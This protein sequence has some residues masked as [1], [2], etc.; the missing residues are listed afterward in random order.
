MSCLREG[1]KPALASERDRNQA[2]PQRGNE[3]KEGAP[4]RSRGTPTPGSSQ[5]APGRSRGTPTPGGSNGG[6]RPVPQ[7]G[8]ETKPV[9]QRGNETMG[10]PARWAAASARTLARRL[11]R[12]R[13]W[14]LGG[15]VADALQWRAKVVRDALEAQWE[16]EQQ[17]GA[18]F[19]TLHEVMQ[20]A[21]LLRSCTRGRISE[22]EE[23]RNLS[24]W[25]RHAP[26]PGAVGLRAWPDGIDAG[27]LEQ[28]RDMMYVDQRTE[29]ESGQQDGPVNEEA[30]LAGV[31]TPRWAGGTP[32]EAASCA[33]SEDLDAEGVLDSKLDANEEEEEAHQEEVVPEQPEADNVA[34]PARA[35]TECLAGRAEPP[36]WARKPRPSAE[37]WTPEPSLAERAGRRARTSVLQERG[38]RSDRRCHLSKKWGSEAGPPVVLAAAS[39]RP[40]SSKGRVHSAACRTTLSPRTPWPSKEMQMPLLRS[41]WASEALWRGATPRCKG[42]PSRMPWTQRL[43]TAWPCTPWTTPQTRSTCGP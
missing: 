3:T 9:P 29:G 39:R 42:Q 20:A 10:A 1:T 6:H 5:L 7:R 36:P 22:L 16:T 34:M 37:G 25:A 11:R 23:L 12:R 17:L 30:D 31:P 33:S 21:K 26:P 19:G 4:G 28:F 43:P 40:A 14:E 38:P 8:N 35:M 18:H 24:A 32:S 2:L 41:D 13:R 27:K 15:T